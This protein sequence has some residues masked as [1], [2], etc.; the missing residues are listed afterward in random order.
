LVARGFQKCEHTKTDMTTAAAPT[1]HEL[2]YA[3]MDRGDLH[4]ASRAFDELLKARPDRSV[5]HYMRG[6]VHKYMRDWPASLH[7]N[8]C[9]IELAGEGENLEAEHWNA[10]IA[11]TALGEWGEA[12]RLWTAVG[13]AIGEGAGPIDQDFGVAVVRLNAWAAG[14]TVFMR[15]IDPVRARLLNVPLP[16]G[17]YRFGDIVLHDGAAT[18]YRWDGA[19]RKVPVF[20][21][22]ERLVESEFKTFTVFVGCDDAAAL[23]ALVDSTGPGIGFIEDWT[24]GI[25]YSCLRCSY[26]TPHRHVDRSDDGWEVDRNVG[27]ASQSRLAVDKLLADWAAAGPGRRIDAV[28]TRVCAIP[29]PLDGSVW[30]HGPDDGDESGKT[31]E[32]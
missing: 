17:G 19:E 30:W 31:A 25:A 11:A 26:G 5:Y 23:R 28:M 4:E 10:A 32:A 15:R 6:L 21:A 7:H 14:E 9:A 1:V 3:A 24:S 18:G 2:A 20:N 22:L 29:P 12:R 13:I 8:L 16:E 27:V